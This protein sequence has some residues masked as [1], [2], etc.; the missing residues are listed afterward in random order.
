[1]GPGPPSE[2]DAEASSRPRLF[3]YPLLPPYHLEDNWRFRNL[4]QAVR[5]SKYYAKNPMCADFFII[6]NMRCH[7]PIA[8]KKSM[9]M[10][11]MI[12]Y[13]KFKYPFWNQTTAR[14]LTR[15]FMLMPCDHGPGDCMYDRDWILK[16]EPI[17]ENIRPNNPSRRLGFLTLNGDPQ[18]HN[19][20]IRGVDIRLPQEEWHECGPFCGMSRLDRMRFERHLINPIHRRYSPWFE[21]D[22]GRRDETLRRHRRVKFFW[23]GASRSNKGIR[24]SVI[25]YHANRSGFLLRD[26]SATGHLRHLV[27]NIDIPEVHSKSAFIASAMA[28]SDF[29]FSP[30]GQSQGDSDRYLPAILYGCIPV[31]T[32]KGEFGPF[33]EIISWPD[34]SLQVERS[35]IP[36]LHEILESVPFQ[37][38]L[39]MRRAM[40]QVWQRLL[41]TSTRTPGGRPFLHESGWQDA[42]HTLMETFSLRLQK[43]MEVLA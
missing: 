6:S 20:Y 19:F 7:Q 22:Y 30:L 5:T 10:Q 23:A 21:A 28:N 31:F 40:G 4:K 18:M 33:D 16:G 14:N 27:D 2:C 35:D 43:E 34:V 25:K 32:H 15:H 29:C 9:Q 13:I 36:K 11:K 1:M 24:G 12:K 37:R 41:W 3:W 8:M 42:F 26:T 39:E 17:D 38:I